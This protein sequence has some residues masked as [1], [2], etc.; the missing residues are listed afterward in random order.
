MQKRLLTLITTS[1]LSFKSMDVFSSDTDVLDNTEHFGS[2]LKRQIAE[3]SIL[4]Y[5]N[6]I[7]FG[8]AAKP[9]YSTFRKAMIGYLNL[10]NQKKLGEKQVITIIDYSLPSTEK[11]L[12]VINLKAKKLL[13]HELVA[14]GRN[15]GNLYASNFS[16]RM[17]SNATSLG[18]YITGETYTGKFGRALRLDGQEL[19]I[20]NRARERGVVMHGADY[21]SE[22]IAAAGR[23]G[24][25]LGCPALA[26]DNKDEIID[27][28][29]NKTVMYINGSDF[30][31]D[32]KSLLLNAEQ[33][34]ETLASRGFEF[35]RKLRSL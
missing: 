29:M 6:N 27:A 21:V 3:Q 11:R 10:Q 14:H 25:S 8:D 19:G 35:T 33:A 12:W 26:W 28:I 5:Y 7:D 34:F 15:S 32:A 2:E 31:Y 20:N 13:F 24:R 16:N 17:N 30:Q 4:N 18:F 1:F 9:E 23:L 22:A